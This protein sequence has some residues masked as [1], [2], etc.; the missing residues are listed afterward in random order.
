MRCGTTPT[1][2][3]RHKLNK[4]AIKKVRIIYSQDGEKV[5]VKEHADCTIEDNA[6][7]T[8]LTQAET[9]SIDPEKVVEIQIR[10]LTESND[11]PTS[12]IKTVNAGRC[13]DNEVLA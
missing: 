9:L 4:D 7:K 13:L 3:F 12:A 5:V 10:V 6:I 2:I 1:H 11:C 8:K